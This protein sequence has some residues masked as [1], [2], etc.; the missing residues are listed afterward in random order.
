M[1]GNVNKHSLS[2]GE[3]N[4]MWTKDRNRSLRHRKR[5]VPYSPHP[6]MSITIGVS[7]EHP[8]QPSKISTGEDEREAGI[9]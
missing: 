1:H 2:R 5:V 9:N 7:Q 8:F 4:Q 3:T 6:D